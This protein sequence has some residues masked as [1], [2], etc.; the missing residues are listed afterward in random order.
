MYY[1]S[2][3][4][5][6]SKAI[7]FIPCHNLTDYLHCI[8]LSSSESELKLNFVNLKEGHAHTTRRARDGRLSSFVGWLDYDQLMV[9]LQLHVET[10]A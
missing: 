8:L 7:F 6:L 3:H 10:R 1:E 2:R 9:Q 5:T 4:Y